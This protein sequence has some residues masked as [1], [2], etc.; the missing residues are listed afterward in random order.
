MFPRVRET[1]AMYNANHRDLIMSFFFPLPT[2][3]GRCASRT[4]S[5]LNEACIW[6]QGMHEREVIYCF[7]TLLEQEEKEVLPEDEW[8]G[9]S[10][11]PDLRA[12]DRCCAEWV[13]RERESLAYRIEA[14][15]SITAATD[16][17]QLGMTSP[18]GKRSDG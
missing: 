13:T 10:Y 9:Q 7:C 3:G 15:V 1:R 12:A 16:F 5:V 11:Q 18:T 2:R 14:L 6:E 4:I 8:T 17:R